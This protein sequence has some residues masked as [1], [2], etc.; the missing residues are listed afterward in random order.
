MLVTAAGALLRVAG[1]DPVAPEQVVGN[2]LVEALFGH[3]PDAAFALKDSSLRYQ[4]ANAAMVDLCGARDRAELV[5]KSA[6]DSFT[7]APLYESWD[8]DVLRTRRPVKDKLDYCSRLRGRPVW[9]LTSVWPVIGGGGAAVAVASLSRVLQAPDRRKAMYARLADIIDYI[10]AN[11]SS[12]IDIAHL[13]QRA[14][15][16]VSQL[17]RDFLKLF[18]VPPRRYLTKIRFEA[19]LEMLN[20]G[21][22]IAEV[23][24]ACGYP[25]QSA[26]TRRFRA[27]VGM[28]P[29]DYRR[30]CSPRK[31]VVANSGLTSARVQ[32]G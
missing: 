17:E 11:I 6:H 12:S 20:S 19:A 31:G 3:V 16:S 27:A 25:D 22:S 2:D 29:R 13:A 30:A 23:A 4:R 28:S 1:A 10:H 15:I 21:G 7:E 8:R 26:F 9:L 18:G 32:V 14:S 5:G 24:H